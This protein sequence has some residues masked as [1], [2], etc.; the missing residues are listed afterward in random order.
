MREIE[1]F[2]QAAVKHSV[3][4]S[5]SECINT[6]RRSDILIRTLLGSHAVSCMAH[7]TPTKRYKGKDNAYRNAL[8]GHQG[9]IVPCIYYV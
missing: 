6:F 4:N 2:Q 8:A 7:V 1:V 5:F 9:G 3:C